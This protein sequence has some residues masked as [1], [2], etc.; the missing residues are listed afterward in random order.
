MSKLGVL[1]ELF[2]PE[3]VSLGR[4]CKGIDLPDEVKRVAA[5]AILRNRTQQNDIELA[6]EVGLSI[7]NVLRGKDNIALLDKV[8]AVREVLEPL[9]QNPLATAYEK[10]LQKP[11]VKRL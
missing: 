8:K 9:L 6:A 10:P 4:A 1:S 11:I 7:A 3:K 2:E 5:S